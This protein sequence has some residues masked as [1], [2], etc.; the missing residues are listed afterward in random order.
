MSQSQLIGSSGETK[1]G[2]GARKRL[3]ISVP[4]FNNSALIKGYSKTLIGRRMNPEE[5]NIKYLLVTLPKIWNLEDK[6]VGTDL[7]LG[8]FQFDFD[9]EAD[10]ES[11]LK[12][13]P[14]HF[15]Y[16]MLSLVRW[17]PRTNKNYPFEITFW[18][19]VLGVPLQF[20]EEPTFRSIGDA[21]GETKEVDLDNG[22]IQV[23]LDGFKEMIFETAVDFTGGEYYEGQEFPVSLRYEKL[24]GYCKTCFSLCH[25]M[26][27]CPLT[28]TSSERKMEPR[29]VMEGRHDDRARSY[30]G[31]LINENGGQQDRKK[32][33]REYNGKGKGKMLEEVDPK[34]TRKA[35]KD[36][37]R[38]RSSR[39][40]HRG[41]EE[42]SRHRSNKREGHWNHH[43]ESR[44]RATGGQ[45]EERDSRVETRKEVTEAGEIRETKTKEAE[46]SNTF[47]A[48]LLET[49]DEVHKVLLNSIVEGQELTLSLGGLEEGALVGN[50]SMVDHTK[51]VI[52]NHGTKENM[53][54]DLQSLTDDE[55]EEDVRMLDAM[56]VVLVE[57]NELEEGEGKEQVTGEV[58]KKQGT[59]KKAPKAPLGTSASNKLKMAQIRTYKRPVAK[60]GIRH[61]DQSKQEEE[62]GASNPKQ[63]P[64][65]H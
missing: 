17:Q 63:G 58:N 59:R 37:K 35:E 7:G 15:D 4:H 46:P 14:F 52:V 21:I 34:W 47:M 60:P 51:S 13:Q 28:T 12:M 45:R 41:E 30:K 44:I 6:V 8:R 50:D 10:I 23:V 49:Q 22:R 57:G 11:V 27:K 20:W 5:Q 54:D 19:K 64:A 25:K 9:D 32:E 1:N 18:I 36:Q 3:K 33:S 26:E 31:V 24:F 29:N 39:S 53:E 65:N 40:E 55:A 16:W 56:N 48:E 61:G 2:E 42:G 62:K 38:H 43:Q